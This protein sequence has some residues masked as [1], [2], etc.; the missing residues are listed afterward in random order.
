MGAKRD[1]I[2]SHMELIE[3]WHKLPK[4][5]SDRRE[6]LSKL[7]AQVPELDR[8]LRELCPDLGQFSG[9]VYG[10]ERPQAAPVLSRA[11]DLLEQADTFVS[12]CEVAGIPALPM[13]FFHPLVAGP[14]QPLF[15]AKKYRQ[16]VEDAATHV[17][18]AI[19]KRVGRYDIFDADLM[20]KAFSTD[21]PV[22]ACR[23]CAVP[24][25]GRISR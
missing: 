25:T 19:Q 8:I 1:L 12:E 6:V 20:G 7:N 15:E 14:A 9:Y 13:I 11:L 21:P 18:E 10:G 24:G 22:E 4:W 2:V 23:A 17:N 3:E 16:A 5:S